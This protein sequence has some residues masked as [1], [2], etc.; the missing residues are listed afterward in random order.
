MAVAQL[1]YLGFEVQ[2]LE[3]WE[4]FTTQVLGLKVHSRMDNGGFQL[5][6]DDH[7]YRFIVTPGDADDLAVVGWEASSAEDLSGCLERLKSAG[8]TVTEASDTDKS[9]RAV[10]A[11]FQLNDVRALLVEE[12]F[13]KVSPRRLPPQ[14][15]TTLGTVLVIVAVALPSQHE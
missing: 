5:G 4:S 7:A 15:A 6:M 3:A 1:G 11:L 14:V 13:Q 10:E 8:V 12:H 9:N 2:D